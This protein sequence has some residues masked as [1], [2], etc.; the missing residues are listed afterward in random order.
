MSGILRSWKVILTIGLPI[1]SASLAEIVLGIVDTSFIGRLGATSLAAVAA[2]TALYSI[3]VQVMASAA[4]GYQVIA[5]QLFGGNKK[6]SVAYS[7][8]MA[9]LTAIAVLCIIGAWLSLPVLKLVASDQEVSREALVY[10]Q[11]RSPGILFL[12]LIFVLRS[13]FN[14]A[15]RNMWALRAS[16][17]TVLA[18]VVLDYLL[19]FGNLGFPA[20]G[21]AGA[22]LA[23]SIASFIGLTYYFSLNIRL[24]LAKF[25]LRTV[26][27]ADI[28]KQL[29][30]SAPEMASSLLDY[31]GTALLFSLMG[32]LSTYAL[33][34]GRINFL[35]VTV[36]FVIAMGVAFAVQILCGHAL[37]TGDKNLFKQTVKDGRFLG[38]FLFS[39]LGAS[40]YLL[41]FPIVSIFTNVPEVVS[42]A[43]ASLAPV[44]V[45]LPFMAVGA[46][47]VAGLRAL[48][49]T[50]WVMY[51][52][53]AAIWLVQ[54]PIAWIAGVVLGLG[55]WGIFFGIAAYFGARWLLANVLLRRAVTHG[56]TK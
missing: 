3:F 21:T 25:Q 5:A 30:L 14:I 39:I 4:V 56:S 9:I 22:A 19:I 40:L 28:R 35:L 44:S 11:Y 51:S 23:S 47:E 43:A 36:L 50:K 2:A 41:R 13:T 10:L 38:A 54:I 34:A 49:F 48:G 12:A 37:G 27:M 31:S 17:I 42:E 24:K 33:A 55:L 7:N 1:I 32:S 16:I 45:S 6:V 29:H 18:N 15:K 53:L 46:V 26:N 8:A 52:N 20:M